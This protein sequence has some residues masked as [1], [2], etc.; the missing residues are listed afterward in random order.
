[1]RV[2]WALGIMV[3]TATASAGANA[4]PSSFS[5]YSDYIVISVVP[6]S[7]DVQPLVMA[8]PAKERQKREVALQ[9]GALTPIV[10]KK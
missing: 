3:L 10:A 8:V 1:M 9:M 7:P 2:F 4:A 5:D 6:R